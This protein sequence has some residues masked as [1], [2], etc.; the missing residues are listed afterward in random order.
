MNRGKP[1]ERRTP[2]KRTR[3]RRTATRKPEGA[4]AATEAVLRRAGWRCEA[5]LDGCSRDHGLAPHHRLRQAHGGP[6]T[7]ENLV[8]LCQECHTDSPA[9]VH[10][11]VAWAY[12]VGLLI[13]SHEQ[14]PDQ[15]WTRTRL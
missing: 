3:M 6:W 12:E 1:L 9:A 4:Q 13:R 10:R 5:R 8:L 11:N 2:L 14:A 15:E 7:P